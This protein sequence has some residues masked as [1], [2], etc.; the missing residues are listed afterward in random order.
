MSEKYDRSRRTREQ[1]RELVI[2]GG[3]RRVGGGSAGLGRRAV[4]RGHG[5]ARGHGG[6][7]QPALHH[8]LPLPRAAVLHD[9]RGRR[10]A[11]AAAHDRAQVRTRAT[12]REVS[13]DGRNGGEDDN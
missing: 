2:G 10:H 12:P 7:L 6:R 8:H 11:D 13:A 3:E 9:L 4:Q 1:S 5:G